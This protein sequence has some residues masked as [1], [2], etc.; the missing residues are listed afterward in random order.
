VV[1]TQVDVMVSIEF[2]VQNLWSIS[3]LSMVLQQET[4]IDGIDGHT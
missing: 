3:I 1:D 2:Y 4:A